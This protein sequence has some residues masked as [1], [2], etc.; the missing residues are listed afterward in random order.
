M[1]TIELVAAAF[2][3]LVVLVTTTGGYLLNRL[4][5]LETES[6][7]SKNQEI[8]LLRARVAIL[9]EEAKRVPLLEE[10]LKTVLNELKLLQVR[11]AETERIAALNKTR[12]DGL[13]QENNSLR[14]DKCR[15]ETEVNNLR[16]EVKTYQSALALVGMER[17]E[18]K[19]E[20]GEN[21]P[22]AV[23]QERTA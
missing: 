15:L 10:Q 4:K 13:E 12:A 21:E 8:A 6:D 3:G 20:P 1:H 17:M 11:L 18:T 23:A 2:A 19:P 9:E 22:P 16:I 7:A 5:K 14:Q